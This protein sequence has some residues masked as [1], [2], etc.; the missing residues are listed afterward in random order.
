MVGN[1]SIFMSKL[2]IGARLR[3]LRETKGVSQSEV[4]RNT[5]ILQKT[6][7]SYENNH[8]IPP[9]EVLKKISEYYSVSLDYVAFGFDLAEK[10]NKTIN[11]NTLFKYLKIIE[12]LDNKYKKAIEVI[13]KAIIYENKEN[14]E[15][16]N[17]IEKEKLL[18]N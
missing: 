18:E 15:I 17:I 13:L 4:A 7:C 8:S 6:I 14:K 11:E 12:K 9:L 2:K 3:E 5:G 10:Y 1:V 16:K